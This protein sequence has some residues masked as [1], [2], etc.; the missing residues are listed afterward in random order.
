MDGRPRVSPSVHGPGLSHGSQFHDLRHDALGGWREA[1]AGEGF[2]VN[3]RYG[4]VRANVTTSRLEAVELKTG[5]LVWGSGE[6]ARFCVPSQMD[7]NWKP[8]GMPEAVTLYRMPEGTNESVPPTVA[9][10]VR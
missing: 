4:D 7:F 5:A 3:G 9:D 6:A 8:G 2:T 1:A 10:V